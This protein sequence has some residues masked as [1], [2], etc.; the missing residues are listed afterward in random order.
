METDMGGRSD[1]GF[2]G[3]EN[4]IRQI[5]AYC[6]RCG[7]GT[8]MNWRTTSEIEQHSQPLAEHS[9]APHYMC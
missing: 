5:N 6:G 1:G 8:D 4:W 2:L 9:T 3:P 7:A